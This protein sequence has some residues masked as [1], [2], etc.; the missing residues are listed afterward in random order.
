MTISR[1]HKLVLL[2]AIL[3]AAGSTIFLLA[4]KPAPIHQG[5]SYNC[6]KTERGWGYDIMVNDTIIIHQPFIPGKSGVNGFNTQQEAS[7][8]AQNVIEKIKSQ[9]FPL[10]NHQQLQRPAVSRTQSK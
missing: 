9:E 7:A 10:V 4:I 1:K 2:V 6:F 3:F 5:L 8:D